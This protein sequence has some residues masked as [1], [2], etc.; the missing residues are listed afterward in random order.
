METSEPVVGR[1]WTVPSQATGEEAWLSERKTPIRGE[2][3]DAIDRILHVQARLR[4]PIARQDWFLLHQH[5]DRS[6]IL[7]YNPNGLSDM[8]FYAP[9]VGFKL[10]CL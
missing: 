9:Q 2:D 6:E 1:E 7:W 10:Q 4:H 8:H 3:R 5:I